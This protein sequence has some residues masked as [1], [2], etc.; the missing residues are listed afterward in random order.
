MRT[1]DVPP[2]AEHG[3]GTE[4]IGRQATLLQARRKFIQGSVG[5]SAFIATLANRSAFASGGG[6]GDWVSFQTQQICSVNPSHGGLTN[7]A[8][9]GTC[10]HCDH[11][12]C[13][14]SNW[15]GCSTSD[16]FTKY[17]WTPTVSSCGFS[18]DTFWN[19]LNACY[20]SGSDS[21]GSY[22][23]IGKYGQGTAQ[24]NACWFA[25][26]F[27]N[28]ACYPSSF[29]YTCTQFAAACTAAFNTPN[30]TGGGTNLS[31]Q[32]CSVITSICSQSPI[33]KIHQSTYGNTWC[34]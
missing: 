9:S 22:Y 17:G 1:D 24:Y 33:G 8:S 14:K 31:N 12:S 29:G 20:N 3:D 34:W 5:V 4:V 2:A 10:Y 26:G 21:Q 27:V 6:V 19:H 28:A 13:N 7:T 32:I 23:N 15:T 25:C 16:T 30:C 18:D 11:Y